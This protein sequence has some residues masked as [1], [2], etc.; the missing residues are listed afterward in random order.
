MPSVDPEGA[1]GLDVL[2]A[3]I[4]EHGSHGIEGATLDGCLIDARIRLDDP[5]LA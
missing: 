1:S 5:E 3:V 2:D 4:D